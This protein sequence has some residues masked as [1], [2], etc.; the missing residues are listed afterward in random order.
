MATKYAFAQGL[1]ELR[2]LFCQTSEQSAA[3]RTF[4]TKTYPTMKKH[5]PNTPILIREASGIEPKVYARFDF[6]KEKVLSLKGLDDKAIETILLNQKLAFLKALQAM[7][8]FGQQFGPQIGGVV[9]T[10]HGFGQGVIHAVGS[11]VGGAVIKVKH[12]VRKHPRRTGVIVACSAVACI[13]VA[14]IAIAL[15]AIALIAA[16]L[17]FIALA[18]IALIVVALIT[19]PPIGIALTPLAVGAAGLTVSGVAAVFT[20]IIAQ[21]GIGIVAASSACA[22]L[23]SAITS[24]TG[25]AIINGIVGGIVA[26]ATFVIAAIRIVKV[27]L[28]DD[29][30]G[31]SDNGKDEGEEGADNH[32]H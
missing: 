28:K 27:V 24:G 21:A 31:T 14:L 6:G 32:E 7:D 10:I 1:K 18:F 29:L 11:R 23:Y 8:G 12:W 22:I 30:E 9:K 16:A 3:T 5:N 25:V 2:F 15:F 17:V 4:L 26:V 20:A 19:V 13:A